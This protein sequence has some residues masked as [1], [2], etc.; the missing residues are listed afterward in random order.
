[1]KKI[2]YSK[3]TILKNS[4][5]SSVYKVIG[6]LLS[7]VSAPLVL[8]CLGEMK[9]GIFTSTLSIISWVY[10][11]DL[12]IGNGLR[13]RLTEKLATDDIE[14]AKKNIS[15]AY[16]MIAIISIIIF[17]VSMILIQIF[18]FS[19]F[20]NVKLVDEN[21][22]YVL[23]ISIL[24]ACVNFVISLINNTL[25]ALQE[26]SKVSLFSILAQLFYII[27]LV[28]YIKYS[29][30]LILMV[31]I[32]E[33]VAQLLKNIIATA[34]VNHKYPELKFRKKDIDFSYSN[35]IIAFG[36]QMFALQMA[37]LVLNATDNLVILKLFGGDAVTP[38]SFCYKYFSMINMIFSALLTPLWSAYTAAYSRKD[39]DWIKESL[40]K[41]ALLYGL[42]VCGTIVAAL[43]FVPFVKVWIQRDLNYTMSLIVLTAIYFILLMFT[44]IFSTFLNG[45]GKVKEA[46]IAVVLEAIVNIPLSVFF[47]NN[48]GMGVDGV[49]LGS[50][51]C[52]FIAIAVY[53]YVA[54]R[55]LR[56]MRAE[57]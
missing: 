3:K 25:Y 13:N 21:I 47:A 55:E 42:I 28:I 43:I 1:M 50:I 22:D 24:I 30:T 32:A 34:Y 5:L 14:S 45:I 17:L 10:Y 9:Y 53:P 8:N 33:G 36:L 57:R 54:I 23:F 51:V 12:G 56:K 27:G 49:I 48:C 6:M 40:K 16:V 39:Y 18:D 41:T 15:I 44:H 11:F 37:A 38:Y 26:A 19:E 35:G 29:V 7:L 4:T 2:D 52:M 31:A 46:T 20:F